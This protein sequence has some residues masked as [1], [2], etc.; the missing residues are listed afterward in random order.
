ME[1]KKTYVIAIVNQK[2]GSGKTTSA[3]TLGYGLKEEG[4]NVLLIDT[5][6]QASLTRWAALNKGE[7][8]PLV[9]LQ[10]RGMLASCI[11]NMG[12]GYDVIILDTRSNIDAENK[13][14][15]SIAE[16]IKV[17]DLALISMLPSRDDFESSIPIMDLIKASQEI[18]GKPEAYCLVNRLKRN[19]QSATRIIETLEDIKDDMPY[20]STPII[21]KQIYIKTQELG[22]TIYHRKEKE[23]KEAVKEIQPIIN[24]LTK[25]IRK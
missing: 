6:P 4:F 7:I 9:Q 1:M 19:S 18:S 21:D 2:G 11:K 20:I 15:I 13:D 22:D 14:L 16:I 10:E 23:A 8:L 12:M 25:I 24:Q 17:A 3:R 5:D